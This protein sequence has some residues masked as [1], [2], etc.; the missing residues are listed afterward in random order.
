MA[1]M[2]DFSHCASWG[3]GDCLSHC[4]ALYGF[5]AS[6]SDTEVRASCRINTAI[7]ILKKMKPLWGIY[8]GMLFIMVEHFALTEWN[9][10]SSDIAKMVLINTP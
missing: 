3:E 1:A 7:L 5:R 2:T 9:K 4:R 6:E 10:E 8:S